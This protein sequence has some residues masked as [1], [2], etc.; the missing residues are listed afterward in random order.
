MYFQLEASGNE[1]I[2][3]QWIAKTIE[4]ITKGYEA[5]DDIIENILHLKLEQVP[6]IK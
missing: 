3:V 1:M 6:E 4:C 2:W 5:R